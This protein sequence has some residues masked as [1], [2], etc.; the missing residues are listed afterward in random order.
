[1]P[2][3]SMVLN[4]SSLLT[5]LE[6]LRHEY[7]V[8]LHTQYPSSLNASLAWVLYSTLLVFIELESK[9]VFGSCKIFQVFGCILKNALENIF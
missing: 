4:S 9:A 6:F 8:V 5:K 3:G 1:M 2:P 7:Y